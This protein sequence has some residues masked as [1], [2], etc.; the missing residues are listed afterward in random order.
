[1]GDIRKY[2]YTKI[3]NSKFQLTPQFKVGGVCRSEILIYMYTVG[4]KVTFDKK[5]NKI[6]SST[7]P[8]WF[9][10][11]I[12]VAYLYLTRVITYKLI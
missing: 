12:L 5:P 9:S 1:M 8:Q 10:G 4:K 2:L 7:S 3:R 11:S 6:H